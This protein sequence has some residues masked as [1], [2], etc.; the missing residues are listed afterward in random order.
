[1]A[2]SVGGYRG[3]IGSLRG[4]LRD[5][6]GA[7]EYD[8]L[9]LGKHIDDLGTPDLSWRD[10]WVLVTCAQPDTATFKALNPEWQHT[11][12][13]EFLRSMEYTSRW[14]QW[15]KT[16]DA[17]KKRPVNVPKPVPLPWDAKPTLDESKPSAVSIDEMNEFL[18]WSPKH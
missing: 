2:G 9:R 5:H 8:L 1:M 14:L 4:V 3:G 6:S 10:L 18:G 15:S 13:V 17:S 12:E 7:V 16:E 11:L